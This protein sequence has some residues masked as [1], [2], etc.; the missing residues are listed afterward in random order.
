M[1][2]QT[3]I[4]PNLKKKSTF[5]FETVL[6]TGLMT[7]SLMIFKSLIFLPAYPTIAGRKPA[8]HGSL[9]MGVAS[10]LKMRRLEAINHKNEN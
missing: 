8:S 5:C 1:L 4:S 6:E 9:I 3:Q 2:T 7:T 10:I